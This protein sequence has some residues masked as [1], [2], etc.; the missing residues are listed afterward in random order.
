MAKK[1]LKDFVLNYPMTMKE[2]V[3]ETPEEE[4]QRKMMGLRAWAM[5]TF[6]E[7]LMVIVIYGVWGLLLGYAYATHGYSGLAISLGVALIYKLDKVKK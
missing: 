1:K 2:V 6:K 7:S 5:K 3:P 4:L